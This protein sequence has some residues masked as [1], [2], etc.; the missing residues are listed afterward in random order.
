MQLEKLKLKAKLFRG[1]GDST[2]LAILEHLRK[3]EKTTSQIVEVTGQSQSNV[4]NHLA[5]LLDCGLVKNRREGK[6]IFYSISDRK[7]S[8]VLEESDNILSDVANRLYSCV[9]YNE[10]S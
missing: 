10:K 4:S 2:R 5:C 6:S 1:F 7:V 3:G 9:H 8:K